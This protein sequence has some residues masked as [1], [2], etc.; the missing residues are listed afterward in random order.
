MDDQGRE[1][2]KKSGSKLAKMGTF[3]ER[4]KNLEI[5]TVQGTVIFGMSDHAI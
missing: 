4:R 2:K 1:M 3:R 5:R